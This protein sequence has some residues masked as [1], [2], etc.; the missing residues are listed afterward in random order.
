VEKV[1]DR[2]A[3]AHAGKVLGLVK[4]LFKFAEGRDLIQ[5][6]PAGRLD[7]DDLGIVLGRRKRW[8]TD[9]EIPIFWTALNEKT[10][11][12][13]VERRDPRTGKTQK[14]K[15]TMPTLGDTTRAGLRVL[16]LTG[17]RS[18][19]LLQARWEEIDFKAA[20]WTIPV[21]NQKLSPK[22]ARDAHAFVIP[23]VPAAVE[24]FK[25]LQKAAKGS[26]WVMVSPDPDSKLGRYEDHS[27]NHAMRRLFGGKTP[28]V[29]LEGGAVSPHDLR[30]TMRTHLGKL[31]IPPHI[32]ERCLNHSLGRIVQIYDQGD[33]IEERREA[34]ERWAGYLDR[35]ITG[36]GAEVVAINVQAVQS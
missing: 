34:L 23:L 28:T 31:R 7:P 9:K 14:F 18:G 3:K 26:P 36:K 4:Q 15:Q 6:N 12:V 17:V 5:R 33:Y 13:Y 19:E 2:G 25:A 1:V 16:L 8:L 27:L 35:L 24:Q 22:Q 10:D 32:T 20:T 29:K 11:P 21:A 30:R